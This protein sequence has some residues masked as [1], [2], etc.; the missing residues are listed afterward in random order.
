[1]RVIKKHQLV[2]KYQR[3]EMECEVIVL[4]KKINLNSFTSSMKAFHLI[5]VEILND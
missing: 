1:M 3:L 4:V 5:K 2:I